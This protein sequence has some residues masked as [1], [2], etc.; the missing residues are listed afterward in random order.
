MLLIAL[1]A[2]GPITT[3][4]HCIPYVFQFRQT[5]FQFV[6]KEIAPK[7]STI[8]KENDFADMK[9]Y[10]SHVFIFAFCILY[11]SFIFLQLCTAFITLMY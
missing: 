8:D 11:F 7:A 10:I 4:Y 2:D 6:Q 3:C 5:V 9:V 1:N